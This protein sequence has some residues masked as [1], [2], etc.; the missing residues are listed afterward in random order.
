MCG[1][2]KCRLFNFSVYSFLGTSGQIKLKKINIWCTFYTTFVHFFT[3]VF[4]ILTKCTLTLL[5]FAVRMR[6]AVIR[7]DLEPPEEARGLR[8]HPA[9]GERS[10]G[11]VGAVR[12]LP[13]TKQVYLKAPMKPGSA[14]F[15]IKYRRR[16]RICSRLTKYFKLSNI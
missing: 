16:A 10:D 9:D 7:G 6:T 1:L 8:I 15:K 14:T 12:E 13:A 5:N 11:S 2:K 3:F 4:L